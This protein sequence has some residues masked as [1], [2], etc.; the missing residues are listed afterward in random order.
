MLRWSLRLLSPL[1]SFTP[2]FTRRLKLLFPASSLPILIM[3]PRYSGA[4]PDPFRAGRE[5]IVHVRREGG[6]YIGEPNSLI[7]KCPSKFAKE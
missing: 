5:I 2:A 6:V 3:T 7:T 4:V 1:G